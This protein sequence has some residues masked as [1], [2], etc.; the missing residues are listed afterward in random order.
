M[1]APVNSDFRPTH[2]V[3]GD[4]LPA[5]ETPDP[6]RPTEP[7]DPF[8]PVQ[9]I[10]RV[11]DWGRIVCS[12]GWS[13]WV[14]GRLLVAVPQHPPA[15]R[16]PAAGTTDPRP[17]L[18]RAEDSLGRYRRAAEELAAGH[19]SG[20]TFRHRTH[21][22]RVG[23]VVDGES[24]W[25]YDAEHE[26][27]AYWD[28][29]RMSTYASTTDPS[30]GGAAAGAAPGPSEP[31]PPEAG[32]VDHEPTQAVAP[33]DHEPTQVVAPEDLGELPPAGRTDRPEGRR[34]GDGHDGDRRSSQ[35]GDRRGS[36]GGDRSEGPTR[37]IEPEEAARSGRWI[38]GPG[39]A[40]AA[41]DD[42][43]GGGYDDRGGGGSSRRGY[44]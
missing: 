7:L 5:W 24:V 31:G 34:R 25:L 15:A 23:M 13:A 21:G 42:A 8:L 43:D 32:P 22:L 38:D 26:R 16:Q 11:G 36:R 18:A 20:E 44:G 33:E 17:L 6:S 40:R 19:S 37:V 41:P 3:P 35:G 12:N 1:V 27:W 14:D 39:A 9:L 29:T 28:G 4:G 2:V 30:A 10:D